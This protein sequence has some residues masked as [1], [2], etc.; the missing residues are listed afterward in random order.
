MD[1]ARISGPKIAEPTS[2]AFG[3]DGSLVWLDF[4]ILVQY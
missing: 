3:V 1:R 2:D 4:D